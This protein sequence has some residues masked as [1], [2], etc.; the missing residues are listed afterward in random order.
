LES[1][2]K[3]KG[4]MDLYLVPMLERFEE[5]VNSQSKYNTVGINAVPILIWHKI[6]NSNEEYS[7]SINLFDAEMRY[8]FDNDF[9]V[10]TM[11]DLVYDD[12]S[13]I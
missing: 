4:A 6:D 12:T 13:S 3:I 5:V 1:F 7:T 2:G 10:L 11:A 8:L 9:I